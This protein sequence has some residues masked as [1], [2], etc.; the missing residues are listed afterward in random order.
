MGSELEYIPMEYLTV[1]EKERC[2]KFLSF[3]GTGRRPL[4]S[5]C[6][7][8]MDVFRATATIAVLFESELGLELTRHYKSC[9]PRLTD[10]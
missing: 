8:F 4:G 2:G 3:H 9:P 6:N 7:Q 1:N 5:K 10:I